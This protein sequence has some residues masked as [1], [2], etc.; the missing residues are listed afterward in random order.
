MKTE[1]ISNQRI[2]QP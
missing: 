2:W 1:K